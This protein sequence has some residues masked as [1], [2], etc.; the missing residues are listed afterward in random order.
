MSKTQIERKTGGWVV[1]T[2][3]EREVDQQANLGL[4][5]QGAWGKATAHEETSVDTSPVSCQCL[6]L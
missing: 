5:P 1:N 3:R 4:S 2:E 6:V